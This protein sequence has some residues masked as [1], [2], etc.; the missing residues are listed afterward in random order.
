MKPLVWVEMVMEDS[1]GGGRWIVMVAG[2]SLRARADDR[3]AV[4]MVNR[5]CD[6]GWELLWGIS[7]LSAL[8]LV[9]GSD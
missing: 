5:A 3:A 4:M 7:F 8:M 1:Y 6:R 2:K 9:K